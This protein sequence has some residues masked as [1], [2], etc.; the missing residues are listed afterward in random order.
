MTHSELAA[1][2][3]IDRGHLVDIEIGSAQP[4]PADLTAIAQHLYHVGA[5]PEELASLPI[6]RSSAGGL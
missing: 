3:G 1:K 6:D 2:T 4:S 5:H